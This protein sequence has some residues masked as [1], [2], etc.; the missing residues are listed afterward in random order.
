MIGFKKRSMQYIDVVV[1][2]RNVNKVRTVIDNKNQINDGG[3]RTSVGA[4]A[5]AHVA[6]Y[7]C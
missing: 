5:T 2:L 3:K 1:F 6:V 4:Q 7:A